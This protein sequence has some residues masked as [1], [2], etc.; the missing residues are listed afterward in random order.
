MTLA[1]RCLLATVFLGSAV[2]KA[3]DFDATAVFFSSLFGGAAGGAKSALAALI[4]MEMALAGA[5]VLWPGRR[6]YVAVLAGTA[7]FLVAGLLLWYVGVE[8]CGCFGTRWAT[9][10]AVT[11]AK[12]LGLLL[13]ALYLCRF[14]PPVGSLPGRVTGTGATLPLA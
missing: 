13:G 14:A 8:N 5:L 2:A 7:G 1:L 10:P 11:V 4:L 6:T 3:L 9:S 12:N